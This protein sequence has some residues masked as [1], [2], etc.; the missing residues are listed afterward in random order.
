MNVQQWKEATKDI[1]QWEKLRC[2]ICIEHPH[3]AVLLNCS[4]FDSGCRPYMCN[5]DDRH[6]NCLD[7]FC[8]SSGSCPSASTSS[9][10]SGSNQ[11]KL[12]CP[13]CRGE[14]HGWFMIL[15]PARELLNSKPRSCSYES[16]DFVGDY[17]ELSKHVLSDHPAIQPLEDDLRQL[18][19]QVNKFF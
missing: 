15:D 19:F 1:K 7:Q 18:T 2:P 11:R 8:K 10:E 4:S 6:S 3:N 13:L 5:T 9:N 14:I 16:C 12:A 17:S